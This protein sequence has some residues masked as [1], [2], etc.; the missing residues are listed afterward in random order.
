MS[1]GSYATYSD[2]QLLSGLR[3]DDSQAFGAIYSRHY[4][5]VYSYL[6]VL[7]KVPEVAEDLTHEVFLKIWEYRARLHIERS[8][9]SYLLRTAHNKAIDLMRKI[10]A[11]TTLMDQLLHH[12]KATAV[13][14]I[15]SKS[16]QYQFDA[17]VEEALGSLTPQRR[18][19]YEM[20]RK[21]KKSYGEIA[22]ELNISP[23]TVKTHIYQ[24]GAILKTFILEKIQLHILI[25]L[26]SNYSSLS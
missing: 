14:E 18:K 21:E 2:D 15:V 1:T 4:R 22:R 12:Y 5:D 11:E 23:N 17:L 8:L 7:A 24:T 6:L 19:I 25:I 26:F 13:T 3:N 16:V 9:K 20:A 10:A